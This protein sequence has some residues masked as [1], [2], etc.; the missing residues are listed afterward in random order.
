M[1]AVCV[2]L[3][4]SAH[5][6]LSH[7]RPAPQV[8]P[9]VPQFFPSLER[10]THLPLHD[11]S[12]LLQL[13]PPSYPESVDFAS[14][15]VPSEPPPSPPVAVLLLLHPVE[16]HREAMAKTYAVSFKKPGNLFVDIAHASRIK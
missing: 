9:Q 5:V 8:E 4:A 15:V 1:H 13:P 14:E 2:P 6:P 11:V 12:P 10:L 16:S 7:I 3:Q